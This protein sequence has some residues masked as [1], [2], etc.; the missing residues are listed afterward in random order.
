MC[1][2]FGANWIIYTRTDDC[3]LLAGFASLANGAMGA[4]I[5]WKKSSLLVDSKWADVVDTRNLFT[6]ANNHHDKQRKTILSA[7]KWRQKQWERHTHTHNGRHLVLGTTIAA[8]LN[9]W[10]EQTNSCDVCTYWESERGNRQWRGRQAALGELLA[11]RS[12]HWLVGIF[13]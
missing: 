10:F 5:T 8:K 3:R 1:G 7:W 4:N 12:H 2:D 9:R 13:R 6:F 11:L